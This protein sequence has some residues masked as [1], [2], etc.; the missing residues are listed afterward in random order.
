MDVPAD[1]LLNSFLETSEQVDAGVPDEYE[2][3]EVV[4]E[5]DSEVPVQPPLPPTSIF[6]DQPP[7]PAVDEVGETPSRISLKDLP[8][9]GLF[10]KKAAY[11]DETPEC[12][13]RQRALGAIRS[14]RQ[15]RKTL[16]MSILK[17]ME[18]DDDDSGCNQ[19]VFIAVRNRRK[20]N[21]GWCYGSNYFMNRFK[22]DQP[23]C[24][25]A[26]LVGKG[27]KGKKITNTN[28]FGINAEEGAGQQD[29]IP[30][31]P[32]KS[33]HGVRARQLINLRNL[34]TQ[35]ASSSEM[36]AGELD[37]GA[38]IARGKKK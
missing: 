34:Q 11:E 18:L 26:Q 14:R 1:Q 7:S 24:S 2:Q 3:G 17:E 20:P 25:Y 37:A 29:V 21:K 33:M 27:P 23:I 13:S 28:T 31:S 4:E 8:R 15:R 30:E 6:D 5:S 32:E 36:G 19:D 16:L 38:Y 9:R 22:A 12:V 10:V 35:P